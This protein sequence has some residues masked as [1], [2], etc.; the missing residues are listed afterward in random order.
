[1]SGVNYQNNFFSHLNS[2]HV[3]YNISLYDVVWM[4][5]NTYK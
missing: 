3:E 4:K 2:D 5:Y 1:M